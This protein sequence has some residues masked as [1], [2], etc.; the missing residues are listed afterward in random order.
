MNKRETKLT[1]NIFEN[2]NVQ[3][4]TQIIF[5]NS[6]IK[7]NINTL[8]T[9]YSHILF[10]ILFTCRIWFNEKLLYNVL[11]SSIFKFLTLFCCFIFAIK[12]CINCQESKENFH[13]NFT[14]SQFIVVISHEINLHL[15]IYKI[16]TGQ[17][18]YYLG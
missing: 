13:V 7:C 17:N 10:L 4:W 18:L 2:Y 5:Q 6:S 8:T 15:I 16:Y 1:R 12:I 9:S 11:C 14:I 3:M